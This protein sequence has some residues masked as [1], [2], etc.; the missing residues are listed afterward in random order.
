M[1][2]RRRLSPTAQVFLGFLAIT[3]VVWVLRGLTVLAFLPSI[4]LWLLL[5]CT[6]GSGVVASLQ[7]IR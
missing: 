7:R 3:L 5:L 1:T 2:R 6:V 4:V